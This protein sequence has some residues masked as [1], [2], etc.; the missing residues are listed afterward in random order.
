MSLQLQSPSM[1]SH[2]LGYR[3]YYLKNKNFCLLFAQGI[4]LNTCWTSLLAQIVK[5]LPVMQETWV[6][7]LDW[8]DSLEK[9]IATHSII[10]VWRIPWTEESGWIQSMGLQRVRHDWATHFHTFTC[11]GHLLSQYVVCETTLCPPKKLDFMHSQEEGKCMRHISSPE[12]TNLWVWEL[13]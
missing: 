7:S 6:W 4:N 12:G 8:E 1:H 13:S 5:N 11:W 3:R 10:F 9:G 2:S